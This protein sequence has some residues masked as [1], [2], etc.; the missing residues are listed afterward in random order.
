MKPILPFKSTTIILLIFSILVSNLFL[1]NAL[2]SDYQPVVYPAGNSSA[3]NF[4]LIVLPDT[5]GYAKVYPWIFDNHTQWIV[6]NKEEL[7]I[8]FVTHLGDLVNDYDD[9][10]QWNNANRSMSTLDGKVPWA[11]LP[12]NHDMHDGD[13][14]NYNAYFGYER[15]SEESWYGGAYSVGDNA[16][17]YQLF[18]AGGDDY[19]IFQLQYDPNDDVLYWASNIID[20]YPDRK[21]IVATHDYMM[22]FAKANQRSEIGE[23]IWHSL[24]KPHAD[25]VFLV[26]CGHAGAEELITDKVNGHVVYQ[27]IAD[28]QNTT[29][30]ESGWLRILE[31]SPSQDKIFV[32]TYSPILNRYK[33][34]S[35]SQ[36]TIDYET[37]KALLERVGGTT[38]ENNTIYIRPNGEV[39]PSTAP[40]QRMGDT[41][42]FKDN[43]FGSIIIERDNAV[44][45]G[46][47]FTLQG[48][49]ADDQRPSYS[50]NP[51]LYDGWR[52]PDSYV[53][54][55]SNNTGIYSYAQGLTVKNLKITQ[56]WCAIELEY[57]ADHTII[58]NQIT[59]NSQGILI[60]YSSKN[61]IADNTI[62]NNKQAITLMSVHD[63]IQ[64]NTITN[65]SEHAIKLQWSFNALQKNN[66]TGK[67]TGI[68]L[69][70]SC[71]N[72]FRDNCFSEV[73]ELFYNP[74]WLYPENI[75]DVDSSNL[76]N[77][78]PIYYWINK[79]NQAIPSDAGWVALI[80][81]TQ[82]KVENLNPLDAQQILLVSTTHTT[83]RG[84]SMFIALERSS[85]NII[86]DNTVTNSYVGISLKES[87][88]NT[89]SH[90]TIAQNEKGALLDFSSSN[91][92]TGNNVTGNGI[93]VELL[94]SSFNLLSENIVAENDWG[95]KLNGALFSESVY[96]VSDSGYMRTTK[97]SA[98]LNN[99]FSKNTL[100]HNDCGVWVSLASN[101]TFSLNNFVNNTLQVKVN[102]SWAN[103]TSINGVNHNADFVFAN[104]WDSGASGNYWSDYSD[105]YPEAQQLNGSDGVWDT[106]YV[107]DENNIDHYPLINRFVLAVQFELL[108]IIAVIVIIAC[109]ASVM[110]YLFRFKK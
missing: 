79:Q 41:Y 82:I 81:C 50:Y 18:S 24:V 40:I 100:S 49:G 33:N 60:S 61:L 15:F 26:L 93:G 88:N 51:D 6:D 76:I 30:L 102:P 36:F 45:D 16:N 65:S 35:A 10:T 110:V 27:M 37:V 106:N 67:S 46:A 12:G 86:S 99:T 4:T 66:I 53:T 77:G 90:N 87:T 57:L 71:R 56:C 75:Q 55:E 29:N 32:K 44:I 22:G 80:N 21:V 19:L 8:L 69:E 73:S 78:K 1:I 97:V 3:E 13:V 38:N 94:A 9:M 103:I 108:W 74:N 28:F 109:I 96:I 48:T 2:E 31:F 92:F 17:S 104:F 42:T 39:E 72:T 107:I 7:N 43:I 91:S 101:N 95:V 11:V 105:K 23:R 84:N 68:K 59:D 58:Q 70:G 62:V 83:V 14:S 89:I 5:Q 64:N 25:Q 52:R 85:N 34:D 20:A 98:S 54:P 47:G 63:T